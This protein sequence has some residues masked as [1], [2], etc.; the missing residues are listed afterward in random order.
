MFHKTIESAS[1]QMLFGYTVSGLIPIWSSPHVKVY[2]KF[3]F[4]FDE[5]LKCKVVIYM[6]SV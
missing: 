4:S 3:R 1:S 6:I 5:R 2:V